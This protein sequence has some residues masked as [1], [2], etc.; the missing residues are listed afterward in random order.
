MRR[1]WAV[2]LVVLFV[3]ACSD[4]EPGGPQP[5][6]IVGSYN[7]ETING[8]PLPIP[9]IL[10]PGAYLV[11]QRG[12]DISINENGTTVE[13]AMLRFYTNDPERGVIFEDDTT[14]IFGVWEAEDSVLLVTTANDFSFGYVSGNRLTLSFEAGDSLYTQV[15]RRR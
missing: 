9:L 14:T 8:Q 4:D 1:V 11:E 12:G 3:A 13:R 15:F 7:L 10:F 6:Q 2:V 5:I